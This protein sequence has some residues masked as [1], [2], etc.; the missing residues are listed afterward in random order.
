M[1]TTL[2]P[3]DGL[4]SGETGLKLY[5]VEFANLDD[6]AKVMEYLKSVLD[7]L[8]QYPDLSEVLT[9]PVSKVCVYVRVCAFVHAHVDF[10]IIFLLSFCLV[11]FGCV[12]AFD[13]N[14]LI[15]KKI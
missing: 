10:C 14:I 9:W 8:N 11:F 2:D 12:S 15:N 4:K 7:K 13:D 5:G 3:N 1:R 6:S